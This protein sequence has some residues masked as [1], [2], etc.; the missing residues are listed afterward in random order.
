MR[1]AGLVLLSVV[2]ALAARVAIVADP[3][4]DPQARY[5]MAKLEQS[6]QAKGLSVIYSR[7]DDAI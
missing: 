2:P 7:P 6:L 1:I 4:L 5:G 3:Q